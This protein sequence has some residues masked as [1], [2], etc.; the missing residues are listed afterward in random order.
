MPLQFKSTPSKKANTILIAFVKDKV[1][2]QL[3]KEYGGL[4]YDIDIKT[5]GKDLTSFL[6]PEKNQRVHI[7]GLGEEKDQAKSYTFYR[8]FL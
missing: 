5:N 7:L 3:I 4:K 2:H 8:S 6:H 1:D